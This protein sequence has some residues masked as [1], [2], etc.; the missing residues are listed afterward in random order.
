MCLQL[1]FW[2]L[3]QNIA[4]ESANRY[5]GNGHVIGVCDPAATGVPLTFKSV[6]S[7]RARAKWFCH[8]HSGGLLYST[9]AIP[10]QKRVS[11]AIGFVWVPPKR[12]PAVNVQAYDV[13]AEDM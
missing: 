4:D 9:V 6:M 2:E 5:C 10:D 1:N 13:Q 8:F 11:C 7:I 3:G 12:F